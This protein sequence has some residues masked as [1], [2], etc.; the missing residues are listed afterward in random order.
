[1][2]FAKVHVV[3]NG[4]VIAYADRT[5][6]PS[7]TVCVAATVGIRCVRARARTHRIRPRDRALG[8]KAIR[9]SNRRIR[10]EHLHN[11]RV[12]AARKEARAS[13]DL[14]NERPGDPF[15]AAHDQGLVVERGGLDQ[16]V[17]R[18]GQIEGGDLRRSHL[19]AKALRISAH[20]ATNLHAHT[21][22][23]EGPSR[24]S[25]LE[26]GTGGGLT[27]KESLNM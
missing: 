2:A 3:C 20:T 24:G 8:I 16:V 4:Y 14:A 26:A 18:E 15:L 19:E 9:V 17:H 7:Y 5:V 21:V 11:E 22:W 6:Q 12:G 13:V 1:M 10:V 27:S 25:R 23:A